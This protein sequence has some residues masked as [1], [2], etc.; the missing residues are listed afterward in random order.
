MSEVKY[1][2]FFKSNCQIVNFY[3]PKL[4]FFFPAHFCHKNLPLS[5]IWC[6]EVLKE[7]A[8]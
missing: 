2:I 1:R 6:S 7:F 4:N 5:N 8:K 3:V